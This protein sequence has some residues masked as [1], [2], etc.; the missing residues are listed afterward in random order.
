MKMVALR[1][2]GKTFEAESGSSLG[3]VIHSSAAAF[4]QSVTLSQPRGIYCGMGVC[5]ECTVMVDGRPA[6][7]CITPVKEGMS[8]ETQL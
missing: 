1:I 7:A 2:N 6:R 4:R 5:F 8:V 3:G